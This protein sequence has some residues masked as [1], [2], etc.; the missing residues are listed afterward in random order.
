[1]AWESVNVS[2][3][4]R[5]Y[6]KPAEVDEG[7]VVVEGWLTDKLPNKFN[8]DKFD[9]LFETEDGSEVVVN[10]AGKLGST[11]GKRIGFGSYVK[12]IYLG[13]KKIE[14]GPRAGKDAHQFDF[15]VDP[16][17]ARNVEDSW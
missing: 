15:K 10:H 12:I 16:E 3:G 5:T 6:V 2:G 8:E 1:M 7:G 13:K 14:T 17:K 4:N 11:L 9:Y